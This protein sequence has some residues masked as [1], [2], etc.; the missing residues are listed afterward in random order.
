M[1]ESAITLV[2]MIERGQTLT[3]YSYKIWPG[4]WRMCPHLAHVRAASWCQPSWHRLACGAMPHS[5]PR[6]PHE[7]TTLID[8]GQ[9]LTKYSYKIWPGFWRM[10]PISRTCMPLHG[11]SPAGVDWTAGPRR[12]EGPGALIERQRCKARPTQLLDEA[13]RMAP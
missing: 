3:K 4:F 9:T 13:S 10:C 2:V 12:T 6:C 11:A 7:T 5:R 1:C 8:R